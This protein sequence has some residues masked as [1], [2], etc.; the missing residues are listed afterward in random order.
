MRTAEMWEP[1]ET[2]T[3][4]DQ[5]PQS[6]GAYPRHVPAQEPVRQVRLLRSPS[7]ETRRLPTGSPNCPR[8]WFTTHLQHLRLFRRRRAWISRKA[9]R[10]RLARIALRVG[11]TQSLPEERRAQQRRCSGTSASTRKQTCTLLLPTVRQLLLRST[12]T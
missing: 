8:T 12:S 4:V 1:T 5:R 3:R 9:P 2:W 7:M 11:R 10:V 6:M